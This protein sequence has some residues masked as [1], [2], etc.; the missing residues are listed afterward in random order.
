MF[1]IN[2]VWLSGVVRTHPKIRK[3]SE[4]TKLTSFTVSVLEEWTTLSGEQRSHRNDIVVEVLGKE[5]ENICGL[6]SPGDWVSVDGYMRSETFKGKS[7]LRI[8]VFNISY[9]R[10]VNHGESSGK[11]AGGNQQ[12]L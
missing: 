3:I 12:A 7:L 2:K 4:K 11:M 10:S 6:L 1:Y 5:A 9:E 8:R